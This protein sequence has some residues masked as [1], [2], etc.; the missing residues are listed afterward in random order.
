MTQNLPKRRLTENQ[1]KVL[2]YLTGRDWT[3]TW[4]IE[5]YANAK[6]SSLDGMLTR[7][8]IEKRAIID[9]VNPGRM[10]NTYRITTKG[11]A[12]WKELEK[13]LEIVRL[14][15]EMKRVM[16]EGVQRRGPKIHW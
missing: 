5:L 13:P 7:G 8:L 11:A 1:A 3:E 6:K 4:R 2:S 14:A 12:A 15:Q 9:R 16:K 10:I